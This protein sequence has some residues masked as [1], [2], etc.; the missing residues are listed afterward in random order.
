MLA[1]LL[2]TSVVQNYAKEKLLN[3]VNKQFNQ[4]IQINSFY[5]DPFKGFTG[6]ILIRDH[7]TDTLFYTNHME[8]GFA[9]VCGLCIIR[10]YNYKILKLIPLYFI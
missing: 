6:S 7:H 3:Y 4:D 9:R 8:I 10:T 5:L 1:L 2:K